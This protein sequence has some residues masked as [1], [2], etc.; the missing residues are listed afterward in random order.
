MERF[1]AAMQ[2]EGAS[3]QVLQGMI[4]VE[5]V[6]LYRRKKEV[7]LEGNYGEQYFLVRRKLYEFLGLR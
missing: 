3:C 4:V 2:Q 5:G 6:T 7:V 1:F